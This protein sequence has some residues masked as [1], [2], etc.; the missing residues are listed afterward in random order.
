MYNK[1]KGEE[2]TNIKYLSRSGC[3]LEEK[4]K[5]KNKWSMKRYMDEILR[6]G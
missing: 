4:K 2:Q 1:K 6:K 5:K 3:P